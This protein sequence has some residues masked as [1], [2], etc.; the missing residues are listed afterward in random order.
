MEKRAVNAIR[1]Y[2]NGII[3][4]A[5]L[6]FAYGDNVTIQ[7]NNDEERAKY[8]DGINAYTLFYDEREKPEWGEGKCK[9]NKLQKLFHV[10]FMQ[11]NS[12]EYEEFYQNDK[13]IKTFPTR[14][15]AEQYIENTRWESEEI[16]D[17]ERV[18][19]ATEIP[20][21]FKC[22][23]HMMKLIK[24][25]SEDMKCS[26]LKSIIEF[27]QDLNSNGEWVYDEY[28]TDFIGYYIEEMTMG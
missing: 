4:M 5:E 2:W 25:R 10:H 21:D 14:E 13:I 26:C 12:E 24:R 6:K 11:M 18:I 8:A 27:H 20:E 3:P 15:A 23:D 28:F 17:D 1:I 16:S 7:W 19:Y 22:G 9:A